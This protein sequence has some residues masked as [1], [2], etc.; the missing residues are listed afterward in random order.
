[1][2]AEWQSVELWNLRAA[3]LLSAGDPGLIPWATLAADDR[4]PERLL[5]ECRERIDAGAAGDERPNLLAATQ[6]L[7]ALRFGKSSLWVEILGGSKVMIESPLL[8]EWRQKLEAMGEARGEARGKAHGVLDGRRDSIGRVLA[9]RFGPDAAA[10]FSALLR[11]A[12][13]A[14]RLDELLDAALTANDPDEFRR[15]AGG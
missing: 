15:L 14:A 4:P 12:G 9:K 11:E 1:M 5:S 8:E 13:D 2:R 3:D 10:S 7:A 6:V